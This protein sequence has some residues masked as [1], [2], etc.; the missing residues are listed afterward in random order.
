MGIIAWVAVGLTA[1]L[2]ANLLLP[3]KRSRSHI[4]TALTG[5]TAVLGGDWTADVFRAHGLGSFP[6]W[7]AALAET[8]VLLLTC[9]LLTLSPSRADGLTRRIP[10]PAPAA[11][12]TAVT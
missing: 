1:G 9:Y 8:A 7:L 6:G 12:G 11:N 2:I 3:G 5:I 10:P 4:F